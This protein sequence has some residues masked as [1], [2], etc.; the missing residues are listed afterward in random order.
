MPLGAASAAPPLN[1]CDAALL[2]LCRLL[3]RVCLIAPSRIRYRSI[4]AAQLGTRERGDYVRF[5][6]KGGM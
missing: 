6:S 1:A 5:R 4:V 2:P 3:C